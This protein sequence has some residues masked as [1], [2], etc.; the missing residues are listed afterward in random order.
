MARHDLGVVGNPK[1]KTLNPNG[2]GVSGS[3]FKVLNLM[4][5]ESSSPQLLRCHGPSKPKAPPKKAAIL[6]LKLEPMKFYDMNAI[7]KLLIGQG[8]GPP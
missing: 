5:T 6:L 3:G 7:G 2:L 8:E 1:S 4:D